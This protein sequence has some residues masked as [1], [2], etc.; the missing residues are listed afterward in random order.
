MTPE[1]SDDSL[2][3]DL[4]DGD[5]PKKRQA[6]EALYRRYHAGL[7]SLASYLAD[8]WGRYDLDAKEMAS[9]VW[10]RLWERPPVFDPRRGALPA[11]LSRMLRNAILDEVRRRRSREAAPLDPHEAVKDERF[12]LLEAVDL[13]DFWE[14]ALSRLP[15][16]E[17]E[18]LV[19]LI[20]GLT[21][22]DI[23]DRL[24]WPVATTYR[25]YAGLLDT[26]QRMAE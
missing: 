9:V 15:S 4:R 17:R 14:A 18:M 22:R 20:Q 21:L 19:L 7:L 24:G 2:L 11:L 8:R 16:E 5:A 6:L 10:V 12:D 26:L 25:R 1:P 3:L 13:A 23:I